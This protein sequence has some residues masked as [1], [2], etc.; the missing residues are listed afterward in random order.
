MIKDEKAVIVLSRRGYIKRVPLSQ[1][2]HQGRGGKG[3]MGIIL[4]EDDSLEHVCLTSTLS[5]LLFLTL[6]GRAF[7]TKVHLIPEAPLTAK[8]RHI[9]AILNLK[10]DETISALVPLEDFPGSSHLF[11]VTKKGFVKRLSVD[12]VR[13]A[14]KKALKLVRMP[15]EDR[16]VSCLFTK[17]KDEIMI[18]TRRGLSIRF[19]E[20]KVREMGRGTYGVRGISLGEGDEVVCADVVSGKEDVFTVT[21]RGY[22]K[23]APLSEYRVQGRAGKGIRNILCKEKNGPVLFVRG[24]RRGDEVILATEKGRLIRF[25]IEEIPLQKRGGIGVKLMDLRGE[26]I[27]GMGIIGNGA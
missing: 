4:K 23:R 3:K 15:E 9:S 16:V 21:E 18:V 14:K 27:T 22:G 2:R 11:M 13:K 8:G 25:R 26:R 7:L 20:D 24:V 5:S 17:G 1:V 19:C 12:A 6:D 10:S